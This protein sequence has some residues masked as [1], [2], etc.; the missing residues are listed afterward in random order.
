MLG[1]SVFGL[2]VADFTFILV[3]LN[4]YHLPG[5]YWLLVI[6][7][8]VEGLLGGQSH[9][10]IS[11]KSQVPNS[12]LQVLQP[13]LLHRRHTLRTRLPNPP[14]TPLVFLFFE[15]QFNIFSHLF[16]VPICFPFAWVSCLLG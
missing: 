5:G 2:L 14:G 8:V 9:L 3:S 6:G 1:I 15:R 11:G 12:A 10:L 13:R 16:L 4:F 7:P